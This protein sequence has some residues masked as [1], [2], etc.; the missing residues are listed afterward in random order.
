MT[1]LNFTE[2]FG[3]RH[4]ESQSYRVALFAWF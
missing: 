3:I 1:P 2:I 4:P